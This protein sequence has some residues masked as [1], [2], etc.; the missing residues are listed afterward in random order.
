MAMADGNDGSG[1]RSSRYGVDQ[2]PRA[3]LVHGVGG[4]QGPKMLGV[5]DELDTTPVPPFPAPDATE[6]P[7]APEAPARIPADGQTQFLRRYRDPTDEA[8]EW[9]GLTVGSWSKGLWVLYLPFTLI[10]AGGWAHR[11]TWRGDGEVPARGAVPSAAPADVVAHLWLAGV[12]GALATATY[13]LWI[14]YL[15]LGMVAVS[16]RNGVL[17]D[18]D[19]PADGFVH[20]FVE[21][22]VPA[23]AVLGF[24]G[25]L[26]L[27]AVASTR[28]GQLEQTGPRSDDTWDRVPPVA[29]W[30]FFA[31]A[32]RYARRRRLH[33]LLGAAVAAFA[34]LQYALDWNRLG[35]AIIA[36]AAVQA[37]VGIV[38]VAVET[39]GRRRH[40]YDGVT[41]WKPAWL[42]R[43]VPV[44]AAFV[45]LGSVLP[46]SAFTGAGLLV[47]PLLEAW[48]ARGDD[49]AVPVGAELGSADVLGAFLL[50]LGVSL[51]LL[52]AGVRM[53]S[54]SA[55]ERGL[56]VKLARRA[57]L[58][59]AI[60]LAALLVPVLAFAATNFHDVRSLGDVGDWYDAY[61]FEPNA[62]LQWVGAWVLV[63]LPGVVWVA[64]RG[65]HDTGVA[66]VIGNIW[67]VLTFWPRRFHP[68][69]A[70]CSAERAVPELRLRIEHV[71][72]VEGKP[73]V[74]VGHSQGSVLA[75]AA[76][77]AARGVPPDRLRLV[78]FGSPL[79]SLYAP[80]WPAYVPPLLAEARAK[81]G[82]WAGFWRA[83]D[84]IGAAV[85][86]VDDRGPLDDP[87]E[88][89]SA[90]YDEDRPLRERPLR[91]GA[92]AGH[93]HYLTDPAVRRA[94]GDRFPVGPESSVQTAAR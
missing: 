90:E 82:G 24:C 64:L 8:Y 13:V 85:P 27:L 83:T 5:R 84:P 36:V 11:R 63:L 54:R 3:V 33:L 10:N 34:L 7:E 59:A 25:V 62:P 21:G 28:W 49:A 12:A 20:A 37:C 81:V 75:C 2:A 22:W 38:M 66:R 46:H 35:L 29:S 71:T 87:R 72:T 19:V 60:V 89:S 32:G 53:F 31:R 86:G 43:S 55:D 40:P 50:I 14:G 23:C 76:V 4:P 92:V 94:I 65:Q 51:V 69:A 52:A 61:D 45:V 48:P 78:T 80:T 15:L 41:T 79:G 42:R 91:V 67:D 30:E 74:V 88:P 58:I 93:S 70:P 17:A 39:V 77:G 73:L 44:G 26:I 18:G 16:W 68:L 1:G 6:P 57:H 47:R 9:G 56:V